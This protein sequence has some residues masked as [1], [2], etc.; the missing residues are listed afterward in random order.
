M[1]WAELSREW[2][3]TGYLP[4]CE[5]ELNCAM[6]VQRERQKEGQGQEQAR[7][8]QWYFYSEWKPKQCWCRAVA[9]GGVRGGGKWRTRNIFLDTSSWGFWVGKG[10]WV[11]PWEQL[12]RQCWKKPWETPP[13]LQSRGYPSIRRLSH[14]I[15]VVQIHVPG[16]LWVV[17]EA[18]M[19]GILVSLLWKMQVQW[20][21]QTPACSRTYGKWMSG[22]WDCHCFTG[23]VAGN[24]AR[25]LGMKGDFGLV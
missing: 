17:V 14:V 9:H 24:K 12:V 20:Y 11:P 10:A 18:Q 4:E 6:G 7:E 3:E 23:A 2:N 22:H 21:I 16:G 8:V 13:Q 1:L 25:F 15:E 19:T 5:I